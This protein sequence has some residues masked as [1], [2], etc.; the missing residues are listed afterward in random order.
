MYCS[1]SFDVL[2]DHDQVN[3][4]VNFQ[5]NQHVNDYDYDH[6]QIYER[7]FQVSIKYKW[8]QDK[9]KLSYNNCL[10]KKSFSY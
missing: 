8:L 10:R 7:L 2:H 4:H 6:R 3:Y 9:Q 5:G 1:N